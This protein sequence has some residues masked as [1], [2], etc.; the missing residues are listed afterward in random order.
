MRFNT[1]VLI[2]TEPL[3]R[4]S[5]RKQDLNNSTARLDSGGRALRRATARHLL[6]K[7]TW[8]ILHE[9]PHERIQNKSQISDNCNSNVSYNHSE[10]KLETKS[11]QK[12]TNPGRAFQEGERE[13]SPKDGN[14]PEEQPFGVPSSRSSFSVL[15]RQ[16]TGV[17]LRSQS[18][19][20]DGTRRRSSWSSAAGAA[21]RGPRS[22]SRRVYQARG[23][24]GL[25]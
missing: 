18:E 1:P 17:I 25:Q 20:P 6:Y 23:G 11:R 3:N 13:K 10:M 5:V 9:R 21:P 8:Y 24:P 19:S 7:H 16:G 12:T 4:R 22:P 15:R 2:W 14:L